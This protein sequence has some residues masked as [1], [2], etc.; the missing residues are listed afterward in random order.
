MKSENRIHEDPVFGNWYHLSLKKNYFEGST[1]YQMQLQN[2]IRC[3]NLRKFHHGIFN[4]KLNDAIFKLEILKD[5]VF[6]TW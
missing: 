5:P 3:R 1:R 2:G 4:Q 6:D